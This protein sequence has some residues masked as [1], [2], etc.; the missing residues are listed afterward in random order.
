[1]ARLKELI[2]EIEAGAWREGL[3]MRELPALFTV[4]VFCGIVERKLKEH[5]ANPVAEHATEAS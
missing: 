1:M 2:P 4:K 3:A 5:A